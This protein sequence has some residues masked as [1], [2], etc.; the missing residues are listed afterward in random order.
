M[1]RFGSLEFGNLVR[2]ISI[3]RQAV[4]QNEDDK[5]KEQ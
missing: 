1:Q 3:L 4:M 5:L 2:L